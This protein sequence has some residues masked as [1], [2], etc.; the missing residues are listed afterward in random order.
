LPF[1]A[2]EIDAPGLIVEVSGYG[3]A[4]GHRFTR[5]SSSV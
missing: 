3:A 5:F 2:G 4:P 1:D